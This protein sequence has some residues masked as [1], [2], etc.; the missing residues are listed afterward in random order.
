V[1]KEWLEFLGG[2]FVFLAALVPVIRNLWRTL[3]QRI[4]PK[5]ILLLFANICTFLVG[6]TS[7][8]GFYMKF[9]PAVESMFLFLYI[10]GSAALFLITDKP[11]TRSDIAMFVFAMV[12]F[13][14]FLAVQLTKWEA[15]SPRPAPSAP[16]APSN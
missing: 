13:S 7:A 15:T 9:T 6:F 16:I 2:L 11:L 4:G 10:L 3:K 8:I 14:C 5:R 1:T 12:M